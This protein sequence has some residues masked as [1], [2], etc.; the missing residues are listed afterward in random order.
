MQLLL[1]FALFR[2]SLTLVMIGYAKLEFD[3]NEYPLL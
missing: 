1:A 3:V 2:H